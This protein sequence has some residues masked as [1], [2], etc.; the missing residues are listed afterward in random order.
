MDLRLLECEPCGGKVSAVASADY[1]SYLEQLPSW[2]VAGDT[3][4]P[5]LTKTFEFTNYTQCLEFVHQVGLLAEEKDHHPEM[6]ISWGKV[7]VAWWTHTINGLHLNDFI[8]A[9]RC[10]DIAEVFYVN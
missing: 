9:A 2:E 3:D 4:T 1:K 10:D 6:T 5:R 8:L 7:S